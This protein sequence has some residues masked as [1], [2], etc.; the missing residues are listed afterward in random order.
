MKIENITIKRRQISFSDKEFADINNARCWLR[1][2]LQF[3]QNNELQR[4]VDELEN[5]LG[6][7]EIQDD[8][9]CY[10]LNEEILR[11]DA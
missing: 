9:N 5:I 3:T 6:N 4:A 7:I 8:G 10:I 2:A 1:N 11:D